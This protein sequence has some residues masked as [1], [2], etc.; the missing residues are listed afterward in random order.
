LITSAADPVELNYVQTTFSQLNTADKRMFPLESFGQLPLRQP[1]GFTYS[2]QFGLEYV[3]MRGKCR[4][5]L[6]F[7][8]NKEKQEVDFLIANENIPLLLIEAKSG[9]VSRDSAVSRFEKIPECP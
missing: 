7:I 2:Y 3:V 4:F 8:K 1:C 5:S 9:E 6:H